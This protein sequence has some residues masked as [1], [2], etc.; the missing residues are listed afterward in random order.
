MRY[1][2]N[3]IPGHAKVLPAYFKGDPY[4]SKPGNILLQILSYIG[5]FFF[6]LAALA[7]L[8]HPIVTC[9]LGALG[10]ILLPQ[11]QRWLERKGRFR[12][13]GKVKAILGGTLFLISTPFINHYSEVDT[14]QAHELQLKEE[15]ARQERLL[16]EQK[17]QERQDSLAY[18]VTESIRLRNADKTDQA[19]AVLL[20]ADT[21]SLHQT[22]KDTLQDIRTGILS[23]R[24]FSLVK[25]SKYKAALPELT[26][27]LKQRPSD[28]ALLYN[29]AVCYSKMG[30]T[31]EA[32]QDLKAA[33]AAGNKEAE[34]LHERINPLK[35][36]VAYY[37]TR[38]CDGSTSSAKG[39]GA[40]SHHGGVCD[41][42]DPVYEEYRKY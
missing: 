27:L 21:F 7:F 1:V 29:R 3:L 32:V 38:C 4:T 39:R 33:M 34:R 22:E 23:L 42:N 19:L 11:G 37:V 17:E 20:H 14:R 15:K 24:A 26:S 8:Q 28:D 16:A 18:Y 41:W 2:P 5:A 31:K 25:A 35:R 10:F 13:K 36:R 12:M 6:L 30:Q 9:L 40:C